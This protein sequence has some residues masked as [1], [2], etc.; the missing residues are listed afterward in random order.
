MPEDE[1]VIEAVQQVN[2]VKVDVEAE[3]E[4]RFFN[5]CGMS[6]MLTLRKTPKFI[7]LEKL[8]STCQ[9]TSK[10]HGG[11]LFKLY[12]TENLVQP[13]AIYECV[14]QRAHRVCPLLSQ[15]RYGNWVPI[16]QEEMYKFLACLIVIYVHTA[17]DCMLL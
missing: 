10:S 2:Q 8:V 14:C 5:P 17:R 16:N 11:R 13:C 15:N 7:L 3:A 9:M 12:F 6:L 4:I 1:V